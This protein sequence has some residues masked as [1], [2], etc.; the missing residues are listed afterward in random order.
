MS[1][2]SWDVVTSSLLLRDRSCAVQRGRKETTFHI[3]V[4]NQSHSTYMAE[5]SEYTHV[6]SSSVLY[7]LT[8]NKTRKCVRFILSL[9]SWYVHKVEKSLYNSLPEIQTQE[10][11]HCSNFRT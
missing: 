3:S 1:D 11:R 5:S 6:D 10:E 9:A 8:G 7:Q 4:N 2:V